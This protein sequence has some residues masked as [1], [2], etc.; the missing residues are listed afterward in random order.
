MFRG[1]AKA[2]SRRPASSIAVERDG[3]AA[4]EVGNYLTG[5]RQRCQ[6]GSAEQTGL[7]GQS[8]TVL[9]GEAMLTMQGLEQKRRI[10]AEAFRLLQVP[11]VWFW[12][13]RKLE[14]FALDRSGNYE[15]LAASRL[16]PGLD[17]TL[18]EACVV[19]PS[20]QQARQQFRAG[21]K[22]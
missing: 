9:Y 14:I 20:W 11:D 21:L 13:G 8:A 16:L 22:T 19:L 4:A 6:L 3:A 10:L 5:P 18:L 15:V 17:V 12:R 7:P 1:I 2:L